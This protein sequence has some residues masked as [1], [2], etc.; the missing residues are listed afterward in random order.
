[1]IETAPLETA[2]PRKRSVFD[3]FKPAPPAKVML[4]DP[5]EIQQQFPV[6]QR[7]ILI[8]SLIGYA[9]FYLVRKNIG[10]AMPFMEKDLHITKSD[11]GIFLS[12]HGVLYGVS[13]F[14]NGFIAD[15]ANARALMVVALIASA[16]VNIFFGLGSTAIVLGVLWLINGWF[17]GMG[18]PPCAR[19][20][21]HWF[22][23]KELATKMSIWNTSHSIGAATVA[24][25][26]GYLVYYNW[27][28][29]FIVP[30]GIA[31]AGSLFLA[32]TLRDTPRSL[33]LPEV[34]GS[35]M[36]GDEAEQS[37]AEFKAFLRKQVFLNPYIWFITLAN[38]FVYTVRYAM[39][40]WGATMLKE[41][42]G[43]GPATSGW[44]LGGFEIAGVAGM[45]LGGWL[46][47][48]A[49]GGRGSRTCLFCMIL[50]AFCT[51]GFWKFSGSSVAIN[52]GFLCAIGFFIYAP[53]ALVGITAANLAT[54]R[55]AATA[56]GLTGLFGYLSTLASGYGFAKLIELSGWNAGF[57]VLVVVG[58]I[59][60]VLFGLAW[61]A[62]PSGYAA[63]RS[64]K[65]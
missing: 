56:G 5:A 28:L 29:C 54:K 46:T 25:L 7:R 39:F 13:K 30:A 43:I 47:D 62:A 11:L 27:R 18:F 64:R 8:S 40:D 57:A 4:T 20:M 63:A 61:N 45:L 21:T 26:C 19:L 58:L 24:I 55:A 14:A 50:V 2:R 59:G 31:I 3:F 38:F 34:P 9:C 65:A 22:S 52:A 6:W 17:Q 1:M 23:P 48:K 35:E 37:P 36:E 33:G 12:S 42:K 60:A 41:S 10:I 49:F 44:M 15:R 32:L 16:L 51:F 53:Q